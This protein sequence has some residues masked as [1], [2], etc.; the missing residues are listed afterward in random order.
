MGGGED[1]SVGDEAAAAHGVTP[2]VMLQPHVPGPGVSSADLAPEDV[3]RPGLLHG[4]GPGL[5]AGAGRVRVGGLKIIK[6]KVL[7]NDKCVKCWLSPTTYFLFSCSKLSG[8]SSE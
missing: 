3:V 4:L 8:D 7:V 6:M 2:R 1:V 5:T